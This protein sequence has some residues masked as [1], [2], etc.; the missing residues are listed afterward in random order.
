MRAES[1]DARTGRLARRAAQWIAGHGR[2]VWLIVLSLTIA[3]C[4]AAVALPAKR[5]SLLS[6]AITLIFAGFWTAGARQRREERTALTARVAA[7]S[8][9]DVPADVIE[10]VA[11]GKKIHAV[12]RYRDLTGTDLRE[13][14]AVIDSL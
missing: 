12:K 7:L 8:R 2:Q 1:P 9:D 10:L 14:K 5:D 13:A 11:A 4:A 3:A 6:A